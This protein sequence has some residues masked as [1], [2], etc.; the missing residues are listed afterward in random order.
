MIEVDL[1]K[2]IEAL[3][4][5]SENPLTIKQILEVCPNTN[6]PEV[7]QVLKAL[8][9][10]Y[11]APERGVQII[12]VAG[13]YQFCTHPD[14]EPYLSKLYKTKRVFRLS[15]PALET[16]A[17]IAYKQPVTR[18]EMEFIRGVN[19]DGVIKNLED[20]E[21]IK[22][23]GRK[24]VAGR[25]MLYGTSEKFL[26]YFG[27]KSLQDLPSLEE[28]AATALEKEAQ[29]KHE[30][31]DENKQN[32]SEPGIEPQTRE[33]TDADLNSDVSFEDSIENDS[34]NSQLDAPLETEMETDAD[35]ENIQ[36]SEDEELSSEQMQ[37]QTGDACHEQNEH[38]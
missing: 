30:Q 3:L 7:K 10:H 28:F 15:A 33:D 24:E 32:T 23:K 20:R 11:S 4:F 36:E 13:G 14:C 8:Q 31:D 6:T 21:L 9:E 12:E 1:N 26:H 27:L 18:A 16:L 19:V 37:T 25:P 17:I 22:P 38:R 35:S 29:I 5:V 2:V 34:V